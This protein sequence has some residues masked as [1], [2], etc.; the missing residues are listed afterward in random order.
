VKALEV[1]FFQ[2]GAK[3]CTYLNLAIEKQ[4]EIRRKRKAWVLKQMENDGLLIK[5]TVRNLSAAQ[6]SSAPGDTP[7][8][9]LQFLDSLDSDPLVKQLKSNYTRFKQTL[10]PSHKQTIS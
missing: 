5:E 6:P 7:L 1:P 4:R 3:K 8:P 9:I 10:R 2:F